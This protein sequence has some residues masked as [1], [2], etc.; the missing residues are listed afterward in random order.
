MGALEPY[1]VNSRKIAREIP[2]G[3]NYNDVDIVASWDTARTDLSLEEIDISMPISKRKNKKLPTP[4]M[5]AGMDSTASPKKPKK[6]KRFFLEVEKYGG[7]VFV[8]R[9]ATVNDLKEIGKWVKNYEIDLE[10]YP[11][12]AVD[13]DGKPLYFIP[14]GAPGRDGEE[15][16]E[17]AQEYGDGIRFEAANINSFGGVEKVAELCDD[18][19]KSECVI[20]LGNVDD[21]AYVEKMWKETDGKFDMIVVGVAPGNACVTRDNMGCGTPQ[22]TAVSAVAEVADKYEVTVCA[23]GGFVTMGD[24]NKAFGAGAHTVMMGRQFAAAKESTAPY[25]LSLKGILS[26]LRGK[27]R[28]IHY[29]MGSVKG[30]KEAERSGAGSRYKGYTTIHGDSISIPCMGEVK[31]FLLAFRGVLEEFVSNYSPYSSLKELRDNGVYFS[32]RKTPYEPKMTI[33]E[34]VARFSKYIK[35]ASSQE[36]KRFLKSF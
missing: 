9:N 32:I 4:I 7:L 35:K 27:P 3:L 2:Y 16:A 22:L 30:L 15:R 21:P 31:Y 20:L 10:K 36:V 13:E 33:E 34:Y 8:S 28:K 1:K 5:V 18:L 26:I 17:I 6:L 19:Y 23:D 29:G 11:N 24:P 14:A 25:D 12:A